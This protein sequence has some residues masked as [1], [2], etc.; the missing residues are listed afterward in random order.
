M[1]P[2]ALWFVKLKEANNKRRC[3]EFFVKASRLPSDALIFVLIFFRQVLLRYFA[4]VK[5]G[6]SLYRAEY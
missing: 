6:Q 4:S 1:V 2:I 5:H 3:R